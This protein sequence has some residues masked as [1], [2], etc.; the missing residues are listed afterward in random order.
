MKKI[1]ED[2]KKEIKKILNEMPV[3]DW[4]GNVKDSAVDRAKNVYL[5]F[6]KIVE[7]IDNPS[8][9]IQTLIKIYNEDIAAVSPQARYSRKKVIEILKKTAQDL[10]RY[11]RYLNH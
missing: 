9:M 6:K 3:K 1:E 11:S 2:L 10:Y 5:N 8:T 7:Y 4:T